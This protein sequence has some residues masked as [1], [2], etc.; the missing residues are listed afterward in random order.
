MI[1]SRHLQAAVKRIGRRDPRIAEA[2]SE[3]IAAGRIRPFDRGKSASPGGDPVL[4]LKDRR[5]TVRR[6]LFFRDGVDALVPHLLIHGGR[7]AE[8]RRIEAEGE[9]PRSPEGEARCL[10]AG[11]DR[12]VDH[13]LDDALDRVRRRRI[14]KAP[15][16]TEARLLA[17]KR[18]GPDPSPRDGDD[19]SGILFEG[20]VDHDRPALVTA[21][22]FTRPALRD[23]AALNLE[24]F[25]VRFVL[26]RLLRGQEHRLF[27]C[28]MEGRVK[29]AV[30]T[31]LREDL[32]GRALEI[33]YI[34]TA[35]GRPGETSGPGP[36]P[37]KGAGTLLVA[38]VWLMMRAIRP[39]VEVLVLDAELGVSGFYELL[40]FRRSKPH[41]YLL[42]HPEGR[43]L[44]ALIGI[45]DRTRRIDERA[46]R[47]VV[48]EVR[49]AVRRLRREDRSEP[50]RSRRRGRI[51]AIETALNTRQ[52]PEIAETAGG[53]V[54][55]RRP[56]RT[57]GVYPAA[58]GPVFRPAPR[59]RRGGFA[60][61]S[62]F[63]SCPATGISSTWRTSSTWRAR[64]G[65]GP[66]DP[67]SIPP[68]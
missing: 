26:D 36:A 32:R 24:Y 1:R 45:A 9:D 66:S 38:G 48:A 11:L 54:A 44:T 19:A 39:R 15:G 23:L 34:A 5:A 14:G 17:M 59:S 3:D 46:F 30:Y 6:Y 18:P 21:F 57:R 58:P 65:T 28:M 13:E 40:G 63:S 16:G 7:E 51:A 35:R 55:R 22:P 62:R 56:R 49:R 60:R 42:R 37:V 52:R 20:V 50:A 10:R 2:L 64:G 33:R 67:C 8:A 53:S 29:G 31:G 4:L 25:S 61:R 12:L 68:S 43:L 41:E 47:A 27:A